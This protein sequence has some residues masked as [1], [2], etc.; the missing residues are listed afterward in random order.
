M[1]NLFF[2]WYSIHIVTTTIPV[3]VHPKIKW[4]R[5]S[6]PLF[7]TSSPVVMWVIDRYIYKLYGWWSF[8]ACLYEQHDYVSDKALF[9]YNIK[10]ISDGRPRLRPWACVYPCKIIDYAPLWIIC[11]KRKGEKEMFNQLHHWDETLLNLESNHCSCYTSMY[12]IP[13]GCIK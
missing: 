13:S 12:I 5:L 7:F 4:S 11:I 2:S 6:L 3:A 1:Y 8:L 10:H 9:L